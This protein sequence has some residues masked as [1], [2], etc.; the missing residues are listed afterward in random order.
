MPRPR[1]D[2]TLV[3][4]AL[5]SLAGTDNAKSAWSALFAHHNGADGYQAGQRIV[6][7]PNMNGAA[8]YDDDPDGL[9]HDSYCNP[10]LLKCVL[11][12]LVEDKKEEDESQHN[13]TQESQHN[14][15][16]E[17]LSSAE[18]EVEFL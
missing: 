18:D 1:V 12:S 9:S 6:I 5:A 10:V 4:T 8:E 2:Q 7:K 14:T 3:D 11:A 13:T 15:T 16:Q 17:V